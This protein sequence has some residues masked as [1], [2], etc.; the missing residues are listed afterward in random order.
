MNQ[1]VVELLSR[2]LDTLGSGKVRILTPVINHAWFTY[3]FISI[4]RG[5]GKPC[6]E[7]VE[8]G[9]VRLGESRELFV[10]LDEFVTERCLDRGG[11]VRP[12]FEVIGDAGAGEEWSL[13][14]EFGRD[15]HHA[16]HR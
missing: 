9:L 2:V 11:V 3:G 8:E 1:T 14:E 13:V 4:T 12:S 16:F 15:F 7:E 10:K 6:P 5:E